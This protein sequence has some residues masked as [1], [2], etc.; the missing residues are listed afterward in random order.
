MFQDIFESSKEKQQQSFLKSANNKPYQ[1]QA[2]LKISP[3]NK[4]AVLTVGF[5][6][7]HGSVDLKYI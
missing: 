4:I 3:S 5:V 7:R 2:L 1:Q 6:E